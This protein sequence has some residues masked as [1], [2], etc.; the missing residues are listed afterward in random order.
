MLIGHVNSKGTSSFVSFQ[1]DLT[2]VSGPRGK[3]NGLIMGLSSEK[4]SADFSANGTGACSIL[5]S[6]DIHSYLY[7]HHLYIYTHTGRYYLVV[8]RGKTTTREYGVRR[9][10][11]ESVEPRARRPLARFRQVEFETVFPDRTSF[12]V[13]FDSSDGFTAQK[14]PLSLRHIF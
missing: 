10:N 2:I 12:N 11:R 5:V 1:T 4:I 13:P 8:P 7:T 14:A 3:V 9:P 6:L